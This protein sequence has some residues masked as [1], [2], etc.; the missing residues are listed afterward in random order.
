[1]K[2][3]NYTYEIVDDVL[4][5][6]D[7]GPHDEYK[8]VTNDAENVLLEIKDVLGAEMPPVFIYR[9]TEGVW[10]GLEICNDQVEFYF[11][12][13]EIREWARVKALS[14]WKENLISK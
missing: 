12:R 8:T 7:V 3:A 6:A 9:N 13:E 11:L 1:M 4:C 14:R 10:D 2:G 5:I